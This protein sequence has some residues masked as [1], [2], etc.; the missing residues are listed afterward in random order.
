MDI[1]R[2]KPL[3][4]HKA[5]KLSYM[6]DNKKKKKILKKYG[7]KLDEGLSSHN[8]TIAHNPFNNKLLTAVAG[9]HNYDDFKTDLHLAFGNLKRTKR[10]NE[11]KETLNVAREK[12]KPKSDVIVGESLGGTITGYL[13]YNKNTRA[14]AVNSG[15]TIGQQ[16]RD[17]QGRLTNYRINGDIISG[18]TAGHKFQNNL[19]VN[20]PMRGKNNTEK[21][22]NYGY[23]VHT[24]RMKGSKIL[25]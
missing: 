5:L 15:A 4:L 23:D 11:A 2:P 12:Y 1:N 3:S 14:F 25:V 16:T 13:P 7:Y 17:R 21:L 8:Q 18:L 6:D 20:I 9:T 19:D 10:Y 24:Q 22:F